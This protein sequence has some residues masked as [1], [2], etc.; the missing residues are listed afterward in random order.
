MSQ[1]PPLPRLYF[2]SRRVSHSTVEQE[3]DREK[4]QVIK[5]SQNLFRGACGTRVLH[6][7]QEIGDRAD[8]DQSP[9]F[10][11]YDGRKGPDASRPSP[12]TT[13]TGCEWQ[14]EQ[15]RWD[16]TPEG[17]RLRRYDL[18][19]KRMWLRLSEMAPQS[20]PERRTARSWH[21]PDD[22]PFRSDRRRD[23]N[24]SG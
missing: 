19:C 6:L 17:E 1:L 16:N 12:A 23:E 21:D 5:L 18:A 4:E 9:A 2:P 20:A 10:P 11:R 7:H 14:L 8:D 22:Q 24:R 15:W 3:A 13:L